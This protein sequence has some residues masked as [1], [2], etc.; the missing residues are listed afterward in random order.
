[1]HDVEE[2]EAALEHGLV[3]CLDVDSLSHDVNVTQSCSRV[4]YENVF[5]GRL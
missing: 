1:V 3:Q 2:D 5:R 4:R